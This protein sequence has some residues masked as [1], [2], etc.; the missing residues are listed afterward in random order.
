MVHVTSRVLLPLETPGIG[1]EKG[2]Q[3]AM[4]D[5][6]RKPKRWR[7]GQFAKKKHC[8]SWLA[9][10]KCKC[11]DTSWELCWR[12]FGTPEMDE[13]LDFSL[14]T[15]DDRWWFQMCFIFTVIFG[16]MIQF[17]DWAYFLKW[18]AQPP[19]CDVDR[20]GWPTSKSI[21]SYENVRWSIMIVK[22]PQGFAPE[23]ILLDVWVEIKVVEYQLYRTWFFD[24]GLYRKVMKDLSRLFSIVLNVWWVWL[25]QPATLENCM[26]RS[27]F[28]GS[29][30]EPAT[31]GVPKRY[32]RLQLLACAER[33]RGPQ[34]KKEVKQSLVDLRLFLRNR[35][36]DDK[37]D[38]EFH[39]RQ[40]KPVF[41]W[42]L[43]CS[44][45]FGDFCLIHSRTSV[46]SWLW[47][48]F[49]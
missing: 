3:S 46:E 45:H 16:E 14:P 48:V 33:K 11:T 5:M 1:A 26:N 36:E 18:M 15:R 32:L 22:N 7:R 6:F 23:V 19:R 42:L 47:H 4:T 21:D 29:L 44:T 40:H 12:S 17:D 49:G 2:L 25:R 38:S 8:Y 41:H 43:F 39:L 24:V 13:L 9:K 31:L 35:C 30:V 28:K 37:I 10:Q 34:G 20:F 27:N